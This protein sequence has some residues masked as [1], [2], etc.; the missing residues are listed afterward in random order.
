MNKKSRRS[1][2]RAVLFLTLISGA[3]VPAF[4]AGAS[5][6]GPLGVPDPAKGNPV[7]IGFVYD[8]VTTVQ[9]YTGELIGVTAAVKYANAY[10]GGIGGRPIKLDVC[11]TNQNA[12]GAELCVSQFERDKVL[13]VMNAD[14][15][16]QSDFLVPIAQAGIP[17]FAGGTLLPTALTTRDVF[18]MQNGLAFAIAGP[19]AYAEQNN[20]SS[21]GIIVTDVPAA[22]GAFEAVAP[23][24]YQKAGV[25][26]NIIPIPSGTADMTPQV[27]AAVTADNPGEFQIVGVPSFT[28][29][30]ITAL[31]AVGFTGKIVVLSTA[32]DS[33]S[34]PLAGSLQGIE[35][36]TQVSNNT[37]STEYKLFLSVIS[38]Y[39]S[40][41]TSKGGPVQD[42]YFT[43]LGFV[44]SLSKLKS[45]DVTR[46]RI[47]AA[48]R[49][50]PPTK[51]PLGD[52]ITFQCNGQQDPSAPAI[53]SSQVLVGALNASGSIDSRG[54]SVLNV[55]KLF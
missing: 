35:E 20:I 51:M 19:A 47:L 25:K 49:T 55:S 23:A 2:C 36:I 24:F 52:G 11:S 40:A 9:D 48:I 12:A 7:L 26:L 34:E 33:T 10:L 27:Q 17:M 5:S 22:A 14:S 46:Q 29:A 31:K 54:F 38:K 32:I 39:T 45:H 28:A 44:R 6:K 1:W 41:G 4:G 13:A 43:G 50:M 42:G 8:G 16:F 53:C 37:K 18:S 21:V 15:G 30:A 3:L